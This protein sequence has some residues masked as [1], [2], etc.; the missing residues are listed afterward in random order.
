MKSLKY[1][2][3][4]A[5]IMGL[6]APVMAQ[7]V[8]Y[9]PQ[10]E[11]I[12]KVISNEAA[13]KPLIKEYLKSFKKNPEALVA[14]GNAYLMAKDC[15]KA[16]RESMALQ[17]ADMA[18]ARNKNYGDA[19]IL[20]GDIEAINDDGGEAAM[21]YQQAMMLDPQ[22][23]EGYMRYANV[24][25]KVS[26]EES[27]RV[28]NELRKIRPD[29][30]VD[31]ETA[32][33][34]YTANKFDKALEYFAKC[35]INQLDEE[36]LFEYAFSSYNNNQKD[37]ALEI[38]K[39]GVNKFPKRLTYKRLAM[40]SAVEIKN[41]EEGIKY[42]E[43]AIKSSTEHT[44]LDYTFYGLALK[45]AERYDEA[46]EQFKK[47][48]EIDKNDVASLQYISETYTA[49]GDE[50]KAIEY[51][52]LYMDKN[53][54]ASPSEYDKLA[55]IYMQKAEKNIDKEANFAKGA[56]IFESMAAKFPTIA[57]YPYLQI[58]NWALVLDLNDKC[59]QPFEKV[60]SM[61]TGKT[62]LDSDEQGYLKEAYSRLGLY[63]W[64]VKD[65]LE[66]AKPYY[67]KVYELDPNDENAKRALGIDQEAQE[68]TE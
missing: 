59:V 13:A 60:V 31:A 23:P 50:D 26:P 64:S 62:T 43:D 18:L 8:D 46:I 10:L 54:N 49:K 3:I 29:Y 34:Y 27:A 4:G 42:A 32:H 45:G 68:V 14:L 12:T 52:K 24:N 2:A 19:F 53:T 9:K 21:W 40:W 41:Y 48:G 35:D 44:A 58:G 66:S 1:L 33:S 7:T 38:S 25:R 55:K 37:K 61:L 36:K 39:I 16:T 51:A 15:D 56:E 11:A 67:Q 30:P 57:A 17:Y 5:M 20:K 28:L 22:N 65:D 47:A 6:S 63:Y